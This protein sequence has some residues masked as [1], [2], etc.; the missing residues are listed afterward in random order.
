MQMDRLGGE[1]SRSIC[2]GSLATK[3]SGHEGP[4][5]RPLSLLPL[6]TAFRRNGSNLSLF[7]RFLRPTG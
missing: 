5:P 3:A 6:L 1:C 7:S 4:S 2:K